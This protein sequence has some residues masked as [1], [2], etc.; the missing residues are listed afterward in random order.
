MNNRQNLID[1][2]QELPVELLPELTSFIDY[3]NFKAKGN[4]LLNQPDSSQGNSSSFL[5]AIAGLGEAEEDLS[6]RDEEILSQEID[7]IRGWTLQRDE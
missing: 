5:L 3:L 2:V 4:N 1:A 7:P 6:E